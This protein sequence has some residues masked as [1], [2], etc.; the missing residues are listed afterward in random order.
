MPPE[1]DF[2][3]LA[4]NCPVGVLKEAVDNAEKFNREYRLEVRATLQGIAEST[5]KMAT[6]LA[7]QAALKDRVTAHDTE[8]NELFRTLREN[9]IPEMGR[10][11]SR[12]E[13]VSSILAI[14]AIG[15][16]IL[17]IIK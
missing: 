10:K 5:S 17:A 12:R 1:K 9:I 6:Y 7:E 15:G 8:I 3:C 11:V 2:D 16:F 13:M 14:V 4:P